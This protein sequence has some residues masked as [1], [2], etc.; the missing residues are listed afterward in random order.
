LVQK[1]NAF[2]AAFTLD[3]NHWQGHTTLQLVLKDIEMEG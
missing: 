1:S 3:E 2:K